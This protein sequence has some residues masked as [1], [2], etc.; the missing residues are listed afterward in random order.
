[1]ADRKRFFLYSQHLAGTGHFVRSFELAA[2]LAERHDIFLVDG[3][4]PIPR[5]AVAVPLTIVPLPAI[6]RSAEGI[7]PVDHSW[8]IDEVMQQ[9]QTDLLRAID[10]IQ[11]PNRRSRQC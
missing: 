7:V 2:A 11:P 5:R 6:Y 3:G 8:Q 9:R 1:M 4:R 10:R